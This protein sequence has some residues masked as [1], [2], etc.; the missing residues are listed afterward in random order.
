MDVGLSGKVNSKME[1]TMLDGKAVN[2]ITDT[3]SSQSCN[4]CSASPKEM[5]NLTAI[6][7]KPIDEKAITQGLS[8]L[9]MQL[10]S[11][12]YILHLGY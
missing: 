5:N 7:L 10:R 1:I 3:R 6:R 12:E 2:A 9:H 4:V 11:F 8:T